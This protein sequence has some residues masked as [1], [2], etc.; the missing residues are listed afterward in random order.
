MVAW[1]IRVHSKSALGMYHTISVSSDGL[2]VACSCPATDP[3]CSHIDAVLIANERAMVHS[4]DVEAADAARAATVGKIAVPEGWKA[5]WRRELGWRGLQRRAPNY[6][7]R[8]SGKPLVCFTGTL[9]GKTR[10]QWIAEAKENG[11]ETTDE[12][13][14]FTDVLVAADPEGSSA[15]LR[16]ARS[17]STAIVSAEEWQI[18]MVDGVLA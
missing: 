16:A 17:C 9:P 7:P 14:R 18:V 10:K 8:Q 1:Q 2:S 11:W 12:P 5:T 6:N 4:A 13:S 15:K 3:F